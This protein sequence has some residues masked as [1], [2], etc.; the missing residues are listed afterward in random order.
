MP[1]D[2]QFTIPLPPR[3]KKNHQVIKKNWRTGAHYVGQSDSYVQYE[4]DCLWF[5]PAKARKNIQTPVNVKALFYMD[6]NAK[7]DVT[8]LHS[9]LHDILVAAGVLKDDSSLHPCIVAGTD[10]SRVR[11]DPEHPRTEV[12]ITTLED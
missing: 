4:K 11:Y 9:A 12:T 5:I 6:R 8:N 2:I 7:V 3:T 1:V 10:G